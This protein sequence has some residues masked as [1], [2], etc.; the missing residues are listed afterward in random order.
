MLDC[1]SL[2][3]AEVE[4]LEDVKDEDVDKFRL[5]F[6]EIFEKQ[7]IFRETCF[8]KLAMWSYANLFKELASFGC[9]VILC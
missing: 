8:H 4:L 9:I 3:K 2:D 7:N 5:Q 6:K 1:D